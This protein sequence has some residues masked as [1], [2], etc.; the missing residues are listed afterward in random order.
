MGGGGSSIG[1]IPM[2]VGGIVQA[3]QHGLITRGPQLVMAGE[4]GDEAFIPLKGGKVP[5]SLTGN[6]SAAEQANYNFYFTIEKATLTSVREAEKMGDIMGQRATD[7]M[8][9][10]GQRRG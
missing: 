2:G 8:R 1:I 4:A 7:Y 3:A 5:V 9:R 6:G 10:S